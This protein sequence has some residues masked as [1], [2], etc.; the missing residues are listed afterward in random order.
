MGLVLELASVNSKWCSSIAWH[1]RQA[2]RR[3]LII[4]NHISVNPISPRFF[5]RSTSNCAAPSYAARVRSFNF[6]W[7]D[8]LHLHSLSLFLTSNHDPWKWI[9]SEFFRR[10]VVAIILAQNQTDLKRNFRTIRPYLL[11]ILDTFD[12]FLAGTVRAIFEYVLLCPN[13]F[14]IAVC[15]KYKLRAYC[16]IMY[17]ESEPSDLK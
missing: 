17:Y 10:P 14:S 3:W 6:H 11:F 15:R 1:G 2:G 4:Y 12:S 9:I 16:S 13:Q 8:N 7:F 5:L